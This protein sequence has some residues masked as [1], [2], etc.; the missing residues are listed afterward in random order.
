MINREKNKPY[1]YVMGMR[2]DLVQI[3]D[4]IKRISG[5][6]ENKEQGNY[7]V[8]SNANDVVASKKDAKVKKAANASNLSVP[9]GISL[10][11]LARLM[12]SHIKKRVYGPDLMLDFLKLAESRGYSNFFYGTTQETLSL[13][14][15]NLRF[16]FPKL[17]IAGTYSPPFRLLNELENKEIIDIINKASPDVLWVGLGTP[18]QQLWMY[19][20]KDNLK[21]P[22]MVGVGAAFDFL[23]GIKLQAP[24]WM[25][26]NG[27]EWLFRF[28][29]EPK[30][31]WRRYLINNSLFVF[32][33]TLELISKAFTLNKNKSN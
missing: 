14:V 17:K 9:D 7:I 2:I 19:E 4:V 24:R 18:K 32:Y 26:D 6:I 22:V 5:W 8:V 31:L 20:H 13:L 28:A 25:R 11:L 3:P 21:V 12:G 33:V 23:A 15:N 30:R 29:S 27:F 10:V 16:K 1:L